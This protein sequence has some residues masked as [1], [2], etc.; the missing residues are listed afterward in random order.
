MALIIIYI[1]V[2][3]SWHND[4]ANDCTAQSLHHLSHPHPH[5]IDHLLHEV[6]SL[7]EDL[8]HF[9][10]YVYPIWDGHAN[11]PTGWITQAKLT[12]SIHCS[13]HQC[14]LHHFRD[15][16]H[17]FI[18]WVLE[19]GINVSREWDQ[20]FKTKNEKRPQVSGDTDS[21]MDHHLYRLLHL[22]PLEHGRFAFSADFVVRMPSSDS[23]T[24]FVGNYRADH[25]RVKTTQ[26]PSKMWIND[27]DR[28]G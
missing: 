10:L 22:F 25:S 2:N 3:K 1:N 12:Q 4:W 5:Q 18:V 14:H 8:F 26:G 21:H 15:I 6:N 11:L 7:H 17:V 23:D 13:R 27:R 28:I 20:K 19:K 24:F 16:Y 9:R